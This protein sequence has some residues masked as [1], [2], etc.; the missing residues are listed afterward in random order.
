MSI[1]K[2]SITNGDVTMPLCEVDCE[3][4]I[5]IRES[6]DLSSRFFS[7]AI[8]RVLENEGGYLKS[9]GLAHE[10]RIH[11]ESGNSVMMDRLRIGAVHG[12]EIDKVRKLGMRKAVY[13]HGAN[14]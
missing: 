6:D 8:S 13:T 4:M 9:F 10:W 3:P 5:Y 1:I 14:R 2:I 12:Y 7:A 11:D